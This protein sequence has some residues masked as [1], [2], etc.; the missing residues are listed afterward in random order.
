[1]D[2]LKRSR[3]MS[4]LFSII[5][6]TTMMVF[7]LG[8]ALA[9]TAVPPPPVALNP[10]QAVLNPLGIILGLI[11]AA[12]MIVLFSWMFKVP[13]QLPY[14]VVKACQSVSALGRILVPT[15]LETACRKAVELACRLGE[16]QKAEIVLVY[17]IEVPFSLPL[18]AS[19]P[20]EEKRG[21]E[22]LRTAR[23]IIDQHGLP[24]K[25]RIIHHRSGWGGILAV[26]KEELVDAI[27]MNSGHSDSS[28]VLSREAQEVVKR[29]VCEVILD[30]SPRRVLI[31]G[32][33]AA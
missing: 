29:S 13:P 26:A 11:F 8:V 7:P 19:S 23:F 15:R 16:N 33:S 28:D 25:T 12:L 17:V 9:E 32:R 31:D 3:K 6:L 4:L 30:R 14:E 5:L 20:E 18:E 21:Q 22:A 1:M 2:S 24:V 27:V 10:G